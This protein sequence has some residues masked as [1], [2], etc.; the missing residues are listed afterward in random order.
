MKRKL[1]YALVALILAVGLTGCGKEKGDGTFTITCTTEKDNSTGIETQTVVTYHFNKEQYAT[2][3]SSA[4]TQK[5]NDKEVYEEYKKA[6]E[7]T[8]KDTTEE[9][10]SYDLKSDDDAM[11][12]VFTMN[13]KNIYASATTDEEKDSIKASKILKTNEELKATCKVEGIDKN[14]IK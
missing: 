14:N 4:T 1:L 9:N 12:L 7:E 5:F 6:Q 8:V 2:D 10:I 13:Y 11:T 3:Y